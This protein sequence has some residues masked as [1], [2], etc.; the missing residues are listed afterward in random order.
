MG[1]RL[2]TLEAQVALQGWALLSAFVLEQ[3]D[4]RLWF[5]DLEEVRLALDTLA[6]SPY[7]SVVPAKK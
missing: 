5:A 7:P 4:Q 2:K 1:D 6:E 3:A